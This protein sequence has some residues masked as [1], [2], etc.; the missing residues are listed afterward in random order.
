MTLGSALRPG[1]RRIFFL[2]WEQMYLS[3]GSRP[4]W[5]VDDSQASWRLE[6]GWAGPV[7]DHQARSLAGAIRR[8]RVEGRIDPA[9]GEPWIRLSTLERLIENEARSEG[10]D[11]PALAG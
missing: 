1:D 5:V 2:A 9:T 10:A 11:V 3:E 6:E 7:A 4:V 8:E